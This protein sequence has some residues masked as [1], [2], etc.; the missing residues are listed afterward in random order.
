MCGLPF[1]ITV[2]NGIIYLNCII[3]LIAVLPPKLFCNSDLYRKHTSSIFYSSIDFFLSNET[4]T[5]LF[6]LLTFE[7]CDDILINC[8]GKRNSKGQ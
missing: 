7:L 2:L 4:I 8:F 5:S 6:P 1:V 3:Y